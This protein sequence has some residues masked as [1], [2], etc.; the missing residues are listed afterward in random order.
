MKMDPGAGGHNWATLSLGD[1]WS[2]GLGVG[3]KT[4]N[5]PCYVKKLLLHNQENGKSVQ[6]W[7]NLEGIATAVLPVVMKSDG[8]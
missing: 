7:Q 6:I 2:S 3:C 1:T 5:G 8:C 4:N